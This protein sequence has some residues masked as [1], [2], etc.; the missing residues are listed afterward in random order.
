MGTMPSLKKGLG[1]S[2]G[3]GSL[4]SYQAKAKSIQCICLKFEAGIIQNNNLAF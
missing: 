1:K 4:R 3:N 2:M